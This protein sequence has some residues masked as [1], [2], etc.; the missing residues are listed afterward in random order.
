MIHFGQ[1]LQEPKCQNSTML[2]IPRVFFEENLGQQI[3]SI[4]RVCEGVEGPG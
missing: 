1:F 3:D 2:M 4:Q